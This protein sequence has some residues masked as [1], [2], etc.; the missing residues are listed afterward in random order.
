LEEDTDSY[1]EAR[2]KY[3]RNRVPH[4]LSISDINYGKIPNRF[5]QNDQLEDLL[6]CYREEPRN[7]LFENEQEPGLNLHRKRIMVNKITQ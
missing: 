3:L 5:P 6:D 2:R 4:F 1:E 7:N